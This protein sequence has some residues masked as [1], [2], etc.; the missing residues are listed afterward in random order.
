MGHTG[1]RDR[2]GSVGITVCSD[3]QRKT[4]AVQYHVLGNVMVPESCLLRW[5]PGSAESGLSGRGL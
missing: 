2:K 5:D 4:E 1:V 3:T